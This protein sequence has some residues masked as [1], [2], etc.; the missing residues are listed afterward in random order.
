MMTYRYCLVIAIFFLFIMPTATLAQ[1]DSLYYQPSNQHME[2]SQQQAVAIAQQHIPGRLLSVQRVPDS[3]RV[4]I[5]SNTG[6]VRIVT[7]NANS[8]A[9][10]ATH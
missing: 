7:I 3:Y 1:K 4:K 2:I 9:V 10:I 8:G 5:L 6:T